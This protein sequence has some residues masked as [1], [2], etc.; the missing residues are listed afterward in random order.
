MRAAPHLQLPAQVGRPGAVTPPANLCVCNQI[1]EQIEEEEED[2][3][4]FDEWPGGAV[5]RVG[6]TV[7]QLGRQSATGGS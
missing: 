2:G 1:R 4:D 5:G 6:R 7:V 3:V